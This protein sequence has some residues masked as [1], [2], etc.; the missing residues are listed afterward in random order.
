MAEREGFEPSVRYQR[1]H[2][3]Q[4]CTLSRSVTSPGQGRK[5][6]GREPG[7][8]SFAVGVRSFRRRRTLTLSA[9]RSASDAAKI[10]RLMQGIGRLARGP[11]RV[12]LVGGASAVTIGW[13]LAT[14][15]ADLKLDPEPE[16]VFEAIAALKDELD[17]NVELSAPDDF[18]PA[19]PRWRERSPFIVRHGQVDF[20]HYDFCAQALAKIERGHET[21]LQDVRQMLER[22]LVD[23]ATLARAF[24]SIAPEIIRYPAIE[25]DAFRAKV[26]RFT[27]GV[28]DDRSG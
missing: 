13:R 26:E 6:R 15:D 11:G 23:T 2:T 14:I 18:I 5:G 24:D 4:A 7:R 10:G 3:F 28:V 20:F 8:Q 17:M 9:M 1:T 25:A 12:Y 21:D 19:V 27:R 22:R 16:G